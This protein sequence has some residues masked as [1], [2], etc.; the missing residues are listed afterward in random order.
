MRTLQET[1]A[2]RGKGAAIRFE[3]APVTRR[4]ALPALLGTGREAVSGRGWGP[5]RGPATTRG[6]VPSAP[7]IFASRAEDLGGTDA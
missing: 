6:G 5:A 2:P 4:G 1:A 3:K 7:L